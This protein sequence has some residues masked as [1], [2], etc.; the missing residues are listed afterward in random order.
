MKKLVYILVFLL[1][2]IC[3]SQIQPST[4]KFPKKKVIT[5]NSNKIPNTTN[6]PSIPTKK[7]PKIIKLRPSLS[8]IW[9]NPDGNM[10][11]FFRDSGKNVQFYAEEKNINPSWSI[12]GKAI[13]EEEGI[14]RFEYAIFSKEGTM[15]FDNWILNDKLMGS[16][17]NARKNKNWNPYRGNLV[18]SNSEYKPP[19]PKPPSSVVSVNLDVTEVGIF[20]DARREVMWRLKSIGNEVFMFGETVSGK[21]LFVGIGTKEPTPDKTTNS[22]YLNMN[23]TSVPWHRTAQYDFTL[24]RKGIS[25]LGSSDCYTSKNINLKNCPDG[26][27]LGRIERTIPLV[28][29]DQNRTADIQKNIERNRHYFD[30]RAQPSLNPDNRGRDDDGDGHFSVATNGDDC[31]DTNSN[32]FP[33]NPEVADFE[34]N[35]EDCDPETIGTLD[36]DGDGYTDWRVCNKDDK[37]RILKS[38]DDCDDND[39]SV[40]PGSPEVCDGKDNNCNGEVDEGV[41]HQYYRDSDN[42]GFGD[43][44]VLRGQKACFKPSGFVDNNRDC[45][46]SDKKKTTECHD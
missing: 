14:Y 15:G 3:F 44:N 30:Y 42:D 28:K 17:M 1:T 34:G 40:H 2:S 25:Y 23:L 39:P 33:G 6:H 12:V 38:G 41:S 9:T 4:S 18:R 26:M 11:Y 31:D 32:K 43:A 27:I 21:L 5:T 13:P 16:F 24:D 37:G 45:D 22:Y 10:I 8:G 46:D 36:R 20:T 29:Y 19:A 35:D 7:A